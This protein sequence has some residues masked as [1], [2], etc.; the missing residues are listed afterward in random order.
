MQFIL[1]QGINVHMV[2]TVYSQVF[3]KIFQLPKQHIWKS[4]G[5]FWGQKKSLPN[6]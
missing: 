3:S 4:R 1:Y 2:K 5:M 6:T